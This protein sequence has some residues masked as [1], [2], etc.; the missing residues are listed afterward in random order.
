M[1]STS[2]ELINSET[3]ERTLST[4]VPLGLSDVQVTPEVALAPN[5]TYWLVIHPLVQDLN[6]R[7][8]SEGAVAVAH[9]IEAATATGT[10]KLQSI[11]QINP[12]APDYG[13]ALWDLGVRN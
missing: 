9:T 6:G 13:W 3:G 4:F 12:P 5:T 7:A 11:E 1:N 2:L 8:L 10:S